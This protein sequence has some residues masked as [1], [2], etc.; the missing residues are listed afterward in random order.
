MANIFPVPAPLTPQALESAVAQFIA[1]AKSKAADR[2]I[3]VAEFGSLIIG[4]LRLSVAGLDSIDVIDGESKK[5][6]VLACVARLFD[7]VADGCVPL[8][9]R[10]VWFIA[11]PA[12]RLLVL[13]A[14]DGML[15]QVL[16]LVRSASPS[17]PVET[18][19]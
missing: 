6:W 12:I 10:P 1:D 3:T 19:P 5:K 4:L 16:S 13:S 7:T 18:T 8:L 15:E 14:A 17:V 2:K 9:A 11:R